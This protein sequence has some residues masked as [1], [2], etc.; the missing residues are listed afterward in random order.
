MCRRRFQLSITVETVTLVQV[1]IR[2]NSSH[3]QLR[4]IKDAKDALL[5]GAGKAEVGEFFSLPSIRTVS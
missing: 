1:V 4:D 3:Q 2:P 5:A